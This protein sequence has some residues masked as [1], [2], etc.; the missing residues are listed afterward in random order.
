MK[1]DEIGILGDHRVHES[2]RSEKGQLRICLIRRDEHVHMVQVP[3]SLQEM[4]IVEWAVTA[5]VVSITSRVT[6]VARRK[7]LAASST[8]PSAINR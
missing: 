1:D 4:S 7:Q 2:P 3:N 8:R 5:I 6:A